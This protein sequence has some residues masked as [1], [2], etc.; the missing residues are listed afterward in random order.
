MFRDSDDWIWRGVRLIIK[1]TLFP[2]DTSIA[3]VPARYDRSEGRHTVDMLDQL[4]PCHR[5]L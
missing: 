1:S 5:T 4:S 2:L 3:D